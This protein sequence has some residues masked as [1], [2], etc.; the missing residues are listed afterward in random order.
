LERDAN[1]RIVMKRGTMVSESEMFRFERAATV[2]NVV[3]LKA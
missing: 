3:D 1:S 2:F